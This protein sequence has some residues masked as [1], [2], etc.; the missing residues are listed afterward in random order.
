MI[1][2]NIDDS[3][4]E[5]G[6]HGADRQHGDSPSLLCGRTA[7]SQDFEPLR[8]RSSCAHDALYWQVPWRK[9][10]EAAQGRVKT[11]SCGEREKQCHCETRTMPAQTRS[12]PN[13][14]VL[15]S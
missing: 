7:K 5:S 1:S 14:A 13:T 11:T 2:S 12:K 6:G 10:R 8:K 15:K 3:L 9:R 4:L